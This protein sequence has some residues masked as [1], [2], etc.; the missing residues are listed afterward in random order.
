MQ[1]TV[2]DCLLGTT[3]LLMLCGLAACSKKNAHSAQPEKSETRKIERMVAVEELILELTPQLEQLS[4]SVLNLAL[5]TSRTRSAIFSENIEINGASLSRDKSHSH[6]LFEST[7]WQPE[8]KDTSGLWGGLLENIAYFKHA[9]FYFISGE[10]NRQDKDRFEA[11]VGFEASAADRN[12]RAIAL[13]TTQKISWCREGSSWTICAWQQDPL[14]MK[15]AAR[16]LFREVLKQVL[17]DSRSYQEARRS[18]HEQNLIDL[19]TKDKFTVTKQIHADYLDLDS[20]FQHPGLSVVDFDNDGWDDLYVMGRWGTNQMLR[21]NRDGTFTDVAREIG[22]DINGL[23]N[24]A[25]FADFDNDGDPDVFI[26]RSLERSIYLAN[27]N[28]RYIDRTSEACGKMPLPFLV[29]TIS[30]VDYNQDGLLDVYLGLYAPPQKSGTPDK[31]ARQFFPEK[32]AQEILARFPASHRYVNRLGPPNLLLANRGNG[33]FSVAPETMELAEWH[34]TYQSVWSD[35]DGDGDPD[36]YVCN[37]FA[38]DHLYRN[39]GNGTPPGKPRFVDV[40]AELAGSAMQGF[41]MGAS[42]GDFDRDGRLDLYVSNM[43]SK[44]GRRITGSIEGLDPRLP[45]SAQGNLLFQNNGVT[46]SQLAGTE[47]GTMHVAKAGWA[48]GAQFVDVDNDG[49]LD[50]Y[51]ASG[52]YTAPDEIANNRDL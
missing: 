45:H 6:P 4:G 21:N 48:Y 39:D 28:G 29:S 26:G 38:P 33:R 8:D 1:K 10:F 36:V 20:T 32:M 43:F 16:P 3:V 13:K 52:F 23:C 40:S 7:R 34:N 25:I 30:A 22:L 11:Q 49:W 17:P 44:A 18:R 12:G 41:G 50:I 9:H 15:D 31:W 5:P 51:S 24:C 35:F 2:K 37:D 46:F 19:F 27:E 14:T 47:P 42:W